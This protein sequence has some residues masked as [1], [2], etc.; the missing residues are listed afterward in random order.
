[1]IKDKIKFAALLGFFLVLIITLLV[2]LFNG[3][4]RVILP[5]SMPF[6]MVLLFRRK[7]GNAK[8]DPKE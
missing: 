2:Y 1:M 7:V 8:K 4:F 5:F 3:P 6:L